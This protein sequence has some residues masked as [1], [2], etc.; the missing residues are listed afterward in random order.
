MKLSELAKFVKG[1]ESELAYGSETCLL[2]G[3]VNSYGYLSEALESDA[4]ID[5]TDLELW[6]Q[7]Y[8]KYED[9]EKQG[10]DFNISDLF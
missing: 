10:I 6:K 8:A 4:E 3:F 9:Y 2:T 5:D 1:K 7:A